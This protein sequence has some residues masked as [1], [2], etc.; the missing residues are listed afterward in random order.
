MLQLEGGTMPSS[1]VKVKLEQERGSLYP[2]ANKDI[3]PG[4]RHDRDESPSAV[5]ND[6]I[7]TLPDAD[8]ASTLA[9]STFSSYPPSLIEQKGLLSSG[10]G[11]RESLQNQPRRTAGRKAFVGVCN[12]VNV[13]IPIDVNYEVT[14]MHGSG[15]AKL[16][17]TVKRKEQSSHIAPSYA[18]S[19]V[20]DELRH[21]EKQ[22]RA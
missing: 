10:R 1:D 9:R 16:A 13:V 2:P 20:I 18:R 6:A 3:T 8:G 17:R 7:D 15:L 22:P 19:P 4:P 5:E 21:A 12:A 14:S 11:R